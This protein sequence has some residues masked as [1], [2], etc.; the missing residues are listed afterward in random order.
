M[1]GPVDSLLRGRKLTALGSLAKE[2]IWLSSLVRLLLT[3]Y[4]DTYHFSCCMT[5]QWRCS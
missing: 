5:R 1:K 3:I 2:E 4:F